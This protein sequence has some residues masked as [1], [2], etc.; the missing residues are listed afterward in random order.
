MRVSWT[1]VRMERS[2]AAWVRRCSMM[3]MKRE[4]IWMG[5]GNNV[6]GARVVKRKRRP[7]VG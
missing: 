5:I 3:K 1:C 2:R 6:R 7:P 4:Q